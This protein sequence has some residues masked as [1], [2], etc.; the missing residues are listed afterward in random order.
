MR[1]TITAGRLRLWHVKLVRCPKCKASEYDECWTPKGRVT[2]PHKE[3]VE[4]HRASTEAHRG[5]E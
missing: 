5:T 4:A 1:E 3:R 2:I